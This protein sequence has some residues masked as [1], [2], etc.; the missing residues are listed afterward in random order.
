LAAAAA[1]SQRTML[2]E[3]TSAAVRTFSIDFP[4]HRLPASCLDL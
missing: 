2:T 1:F 4:C 3:S